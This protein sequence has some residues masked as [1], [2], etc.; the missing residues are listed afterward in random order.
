MIIGCRNME[1]CESVRSSIIKETYNRNVLCQQLDLTS[2]ASVREF[3]DKI[4]S[5]K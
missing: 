5:S 4:N 2:L 3:A 1:L